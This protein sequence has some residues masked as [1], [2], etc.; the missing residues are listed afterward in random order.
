MAAGGARS[1]SHRHLALLAGTLGALLLIRVAGLGFSDSLVWPA[2]A[3]G[4]GFS[5]TWHRSGGREY[6]FSSGKR[7]LGI[8]PDQD[9]FAV[10]RLL[11]GLVVGLGILLGPHLYRMM[12]DLTEERRR[13]IRSEERTDLAAHLHDSVLQTLALIQ[14]HS[15]DNQTM[16]N[17][18]RHQEREFRAWLYSDPHADT[19]SF[20][21]SVEE[22]A[23]EVEDLHGIPI[24]IVVVG[25]AAMDERVAALLR[26][27]REATVNAAKHSGA[28]RVDVYAEAGPHEFEVF[29]RDTGVGFDPATVPDDRRGLADSIEGRTKRHGGSADITSTPGEGTE[30]ELRLP[31]EPS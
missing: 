25:D 14:R 18:A 17:L 24:E 21:P 15:D 19:G 1:E 30:V 4:L 13:R 28:S 10:V 2:A 7:L 31:K 9:R 8:G 16:V 26:A 20:R 12:T 5:V 23:A 3:L 11:G 6:G 22:V 27:T 29:V